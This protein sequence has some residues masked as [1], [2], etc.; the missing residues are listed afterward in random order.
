MRV[1][2]PVPHRALR[3]SEPASAVARELLFVRLVQGPSAESPFP[4]AGR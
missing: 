3:L 1:L 2:E 4:P